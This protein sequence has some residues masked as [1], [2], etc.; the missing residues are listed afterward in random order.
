M[1]T[2][3]KPESIPLVACHGCGYEIPRQ[4]G[5]VCPECASVWDAAADSRNEL[6]TGIHTN[7]GTVIKANLIWWFTILVIYALGAFMASE[8][9]WETLIAAFFGIGFGV[10]A[11][12]G[13]GI[14]ICKLGPA[15]EFRLHANLWTQKLWWLHGPWLMIGPLT[16]VGVLIAFAFRL[17]DPAIGADLVW[18]YILIAFFAWAILSFVC[19]V[20]WLDQYTT[21]RKGLGFDGGT[22]VVGLHTLYAF[23]IWIG[24]GIVGFF[25]GMLGSFFM[26]FVV[27]EQ[28][29]DF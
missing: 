26:G 8:G 6:R 4:L 13:I 3:D 9:A 22:R 28:L 21:S 1:S 25:G 16:A 17:I 5:A 19:I 29:W 27:G 12:L 2:T 14:G 23:M 24:S 20:L 11:S 7:F 10:V 15:H 18:I